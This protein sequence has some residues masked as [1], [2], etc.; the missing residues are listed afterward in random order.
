MIQVLYAIIKNYD[1]LARVQGSGFVHRARAFSKSFISRQMTQFEEK[2][3]TLTILKQRFSKRGISTIQK[4]FRSLPPC[5]L[6]TAR[7]G[8]RSK[9]RNVRF[10]HPKKRLHRKIGQSLLYC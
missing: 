10:E 2:F 7:Q 6:F 9:T 5:I 3:A 1:K 8:N 4:N